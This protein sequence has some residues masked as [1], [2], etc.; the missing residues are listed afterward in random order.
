M[1]QIGKLL[2]MMESIWECKFMVMDV[3]EKPSG[4]LTFEV[5]GMVFKKTFIFQMVLSVFPD[6][7][8]ALLHHAEVCCDGGYNRNKLIDLL[9]A[10]QLILSMYHRARIPS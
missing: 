6:Q 7:P 5:I 2:K 3:K 4:Y 10:I 1:S 9:S 8:A